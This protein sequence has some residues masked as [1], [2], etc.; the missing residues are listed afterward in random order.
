MEEEIKPNYFAVIPANVR[1]DDELTEKAKL[2]YGEITCLSNK[3]GYCFALNNYF[4]KLYKCSTRAIQNSISKLEQKG[5]I[6]VV[7]E[8]NYRR[9]IFITTPGADERNFTGGYEKNFMGE[10]EENF[11]GGYENNFIGRYEKNFVGG[12]EKNFTH[13]N[14]NNNNIN[15][16]NIDSLFNYIINK[17]EQ[18]PKEFEKYEKA[19]IEVLEKYDMLYTQEILKFMKPENIEKV[20]IVCYSLAMTVKENVSHLVYKKKREQIMNLYDECKLREKEY[21]NTENEIKNFSK[22]FY[23]SLKAQLLKGTN[24]SFFV[25]ENNKFKNVSTSEKEV[26]ER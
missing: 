9:K 15:I 3:E 18:I 2:L 16:N 4:A 5:Y 26:E 1:Y 11:I 7:I 12:Y 24:P 6:K 19:I 14:I 13:N 23:K 25:S 20:K 10:N 22:Y 17:K 21:K 8:D